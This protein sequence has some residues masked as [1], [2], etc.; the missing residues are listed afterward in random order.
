MRAGKQD[1][2]IQND[3]YT[4]SKWMVALLLLLVGSSLLWIGCG[5]KGPPLPPRRPLPAAVKDL[6]YTVRN[7]IVELNWTVPGKEENRSAA[8]PASVK[9][10]RSSLSAEEA[11]CENCPIRFTVS[12][13]IPIH[14][15]RSEKSKP[16]RMSYSEFVEVGYRYIFKVI[17]F[18]EYGIG[19]KDSNIVK[20]DH[21]SD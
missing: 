18:D 17:V 8:P 13:D 5:K 11:G 19:G 6:E 14:R 7:D 4:H 21:Y 16:I 15:K 3:S 12:G 10:F 9:V 2:F 1:N 20:F